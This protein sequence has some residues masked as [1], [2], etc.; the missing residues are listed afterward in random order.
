MTVKNSDEQSEVEETPPK[1]RKVEIKAKK[2]APH[3]RKSVMIRK[4]LNI[5][6]NIPPDALDVMDKFT[7]IKQRHS[8]EPSKSPTFDKRRRI[9]PLPLEIKAEPAVKLTVTLDTSETVAQVPLAEAVPETGEPTTREQEV[10]VPESQAALREE[11]TESTVEEVEPRESEASQVAQPTEDSTIESHEITQTATQDD[12]TEP[13]PEGTQTTTHN[14]VTEP[15]SEVEVKESAPVDAAAVENET[16][17]PASAGEL[18]QTADEFANEWRQSMSFISDQQLPVIASLSQI[19][20]L[21]G[22]DVSLDLGEGSAEL[23]TTM[24]F[25]ASDVDLNMYPQLNDVAN[26]EE[27]ESF[28]VKSDAEYIFDYNLKRVSVVME[29]V[30]PDKLRKILGNRMPDSHK[31]TKSGRMWKP[32]IIVDPSTEVKTRKNLKKRSESKS[33]QVKGSKALSAAKDR[34][35]RG[36]TGNEKKAG[37]HRIKETKGQHS[38]DKKERPSKE[39]KVR[40]IA[41][42]E[43]KSDEIERPSMVTKE[44]KSDEMPRKEKKERPLQSPQD[45]FFESPEEEF[46]ID[47]EETYVDFSS[48]GKTFF[49]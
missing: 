17:E 41:M 47:L 31:V 23:D 15:E 20:L 37:E 19:D 44:K 7:K 29:R 8:S 13:E 9:M 33:S 18:D 16:Q 11:I 40:P 14:D 35:K 26:E 10:G 6:S 36:R 27:I 42:R 24:V 1:K 30:H 4:R 3:A 38:K 5:S 48:L 28:V 49:N 25:D 39:K 34:Q 32:K 46:P 22:S 21:S 2:A 45:E 12:A 43:K